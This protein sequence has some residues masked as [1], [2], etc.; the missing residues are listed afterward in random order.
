M[1]DQPNNHNSIVGTSRIQEWGV[2]KAGNLLAIIFIIVSIGSIPFS[3]TIVYLLPSLITIVGIGAFGHIVNDWMDI[4][5]DAKAGKRNHMAG[6]SLSKRLFIA[7][8]SLAIAFL[9]WFILPFD[10][11]S[12]ILLFVEFLLLVIYAI[13][14][15]RLKE[16]GL[17]ALITD[18]LYAYTL[19]SVLAAYTFYKIGEF[20]PNIILLSII[21]IW[22]LFLG[23][24]SILSHQISD[25]ENDLNSDT[26]T[27]ATNT[28]LNRT[29]QVKKYIYYLEISCFL[30]VLAYLSIYSWN[31]YFIL[32][33]IVLIIRY[34]P[35]IFT[36]SFRAIFSSSNS[37]DMQNIHVSYHSFLIYWHLLLAALQDPYYLIFIPFTYIFLKQPKS[38][39]EVFPS[40]WLKITTA[41]FLQLKFII[42]LIRSYISL[43]V[44]Y[45]IFFWRTYIK[46]ES[47]KI[48]LKD[49]YNADI[50]G[51]I[52]K[53]KYPYNLALINR[54]AK[55]YTETFVWKHLV[56]LPFNTD[57]F[58][59]E[60]NYFP[61]FNF[62]G[63]LIG[64][65]KVHQQILQFIQRKR[66]LPQQ[67]F[68]E[69]AFQS[70]LKKRKVDIVLVE[71]GTTGATI[72][73]AVHDLDI[74]LVC[75]FHG[76][77]INNA[78]IRKQYAKKYIN[79]FQK[80]SH[81]IGVSKDIIKQLSEIGAPADKLT[82]LPCGAEYDKFLYKDHSLNPPIF[83]SVGRFT[84]TKSPHLT[85]LA[86][87]EALKSIPDAKLIMI[88]KDEHGELFEAC[89]IL[90]RSLGIEHHIEFT[91][92][93]PHSKV[94]EYMDL[95][96]AFVQHSL[97]TPLNQDKEGTP[98]AIQ[99]AMS[100]GLPVIATIHAGISE[101]IT[102]K[103]T[104]LL[105][106]E[107]DFKTMAKNMV[108]MHQNRGFAKKIGKQASDSL[109]KNLLLKNNIKE[110]ANILE[111]TVIQN[112]LQLKN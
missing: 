103:K 60:D 24:H 94:K 92:I 72:I 85:I 19:P 35:F 97:T 79:L 37:R 80:A 91:G 64:S 71:F 63:E 83:L 11:I 27:F 8:C 82:Y 77:D 88:G 102:H 44:N 69:K 86:F 78:G 32:P 38:L 61:R 16:K 74:P 40:L 28:G 6:F 59:G 31:Y 110:L 34:L 3:T 29:L 108:W 20:Q 111:E 65:L 104:G 58:Y 95:A 55:K 10:Q 14:P 21:S 33:L 101:I 66:N 98:V 7:L 48:A 54:N 105:S 107:Y 41:I 45:G 5:S 70:E 73:D 67:Y 51:P 47:E 57:L 18:S 99:E 76:Y 22:Q 50:F 36:S 56:E 23:I 9:P 84:A 87:S 81:I 17:L 75:I 52:K 100:C 112:K 68:L 53:E 25:H 49:Y 109:Q 12:I 62:R 39:I 26:K 1:M 15:F 93:I 106:K 89:H 90:A 46:G 43:I 2:P 96:F 30:I 4:S 13:P 42:N